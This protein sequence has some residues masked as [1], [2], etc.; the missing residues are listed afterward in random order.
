MQSYHMAKAILLVNRPQESTVRRSSLAERLHSYRT[1]ESQVRH[2]SIEICGIALGRPPP[3]VRVHMVQPLFVAGQCLTG[4]YE[5]QV[6]IAQLRMIEEDLGWATE[7]R[8]QQLLKEWGWE[9]QALP[10]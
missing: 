1:T 2:H 6:I 9:G 8:V 4:D 5:R 10:I 3:T 7:Y